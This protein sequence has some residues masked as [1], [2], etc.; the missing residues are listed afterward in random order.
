[1]TT[2]TFK[3]GFIPA[4]KDD[5]HAGYMTLDEAKAMFEAAANVYAKVYGEE[6]EETKD[7]RRCAAMCAQ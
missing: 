5:V 2:W 7:A 4:T 3:A 6:H 1:M